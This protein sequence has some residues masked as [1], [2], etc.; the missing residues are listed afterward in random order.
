MYHT[1]FTAFEIIAYLWLSPVSDR[2]F[3][4]YVHTFRLVYPMYDQ[5]L[6]ILP[7]DLRRQLLAA[8]RPELLRHFAALQAEVN[9]LAIKRA[10]Q[11][12]WGSGCNIKHVLSGPFTASC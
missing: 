8:C 3:F 11:V 4:S 5:I 2:H 10:R 12:D 7:A 9:A 6:P 1:Q